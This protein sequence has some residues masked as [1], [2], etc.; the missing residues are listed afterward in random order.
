MTELGRHLQESDIQELMSRRPAGK[1]MK[2]KS[3]EA[4]AATSC[5][6]ATAPS[7]EGRGGVYCEDCHEAVPRSSEEQEDGVESYAVDPA[8]AEQLW[9]LSEQTLGY[10]YP[11]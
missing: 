1:P 3:V 10:S 9:A 8:A 4:G 2:W 11:A 7:L 5:W 6:A